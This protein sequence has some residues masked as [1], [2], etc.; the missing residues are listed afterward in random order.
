MI[1]LLD[2][3]PSSYAF[4]GRRTTALHF[5]RISNG[6]KPNALIFLLY[7]LRIAVEQCAERHLQQ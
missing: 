2:G 3:N 6:I 4:G 1:S 7:S 5:I